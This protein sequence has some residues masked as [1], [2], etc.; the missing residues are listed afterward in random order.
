MT[1]LSLRTKSYLQLKK[2]FKVCDNQKV[3]EFCDYWVTSG[4]TDTDGLD[5][6]FRVRYNIDKLGD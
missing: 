5:E 2:Y 6:A 1:D 3:Y 4:N